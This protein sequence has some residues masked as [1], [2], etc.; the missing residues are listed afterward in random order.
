MEIDVDIQNQ[1]VLDSKTPSSNLHTFQQVYI[2]DL[3]ISI[4]L[5]AAL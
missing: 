3:N 4:V 2:L 1:A 5:C